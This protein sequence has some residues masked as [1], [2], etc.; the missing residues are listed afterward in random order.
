VECHLNRTLG[1]TAK[2]RQSLGQVVYL[3]IHALMYFVEQA[4]QRNEMGALAF[5]APASVA[6]TGL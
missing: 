6:A 1:N 5:S 4:V 3:R 2:G